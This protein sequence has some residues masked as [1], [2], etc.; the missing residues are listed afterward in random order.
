MARATVTAT[1]LLMPLLLPGCAVSPDP[2]QGGFISGVNGLLSGGYDRRIAEKSSELNRMRVEQTT[3]E[4]EASNANAELAQREQSVA[5]MRASVSELDQSLKAIQVKMT[6]ERATNVELS[7]RDTQLARDLA[8]AKAR[9]AS[10]RSQLAA[11]GSPGDYEA[12]RREYQSLQEAIQALNDQ[13]V[14]EKQ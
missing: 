2:A 1:I 9:V 8:N 13:L 4:A 11:S 6:R 7:A 14:G 5:A 10:L 3:A 12:V